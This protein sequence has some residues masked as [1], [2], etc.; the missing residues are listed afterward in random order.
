MG[1]HAKGELAIRIVLEVFH[2]NQMF[3]QSVNDRPIILESAKKALNEMV[4]S[5]NEIFGLGTTIAGMLFVED[6]AIAFNC[7]DSRVYKKITV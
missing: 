2:D 7:G 5:N 4:G 1:G 3:I 6:R